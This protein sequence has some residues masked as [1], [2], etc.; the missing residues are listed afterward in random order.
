MDKITPP[1]GP[2]A[3]QPPGHTTGRPAGRPPHQPADSDAFPAQY[4]RTRRFSLGAPRAFTLAPDGS[5]ALFLRTRGPEDATGCLWRAD[6]AGEH[7]LLDPA[8]LD[9]AA[10]EIPE[11]ERIRRERAREHTS[12]IVGYATDAAARVIVLALDGELWTLRCDGGALRRVRT[13]GPVVD[14]RPDPLGRRV[15]YVTGGAL[16]VVE[17]DGGD[18]D[19]GDTDGG[20]SDGGEDRLLAGPEGPEVVYGLAEHVA[21]ESMHRHRGYWWAPDGERLLAARVDTSPV[22]R[23]WI[24]DPADPARPPRA[25]PYPAA[26]TANADVSLHVLGV[27]GSRT[28]VAWDRAAFEYLT[29]AAWD[30]HGPLIGVQ[31]RDQRTLRVLGCD[32]DTG[33]THLLHEQRDPAWVELVPGTP[34]RTASGA[35]VHTVDDGAT[36]RLTVGGEP[37]TPEGLQ[38]RDVLSVDGGSVLFVASDEP[39]EEHLWSYAPPHGDGSGV[40]A[41][42]V[43]LSD[44]PGLHE[45]RRAGDTLLLISHT[46]D[47][48]VF[49]LSAGGRS[50]PIASLAARPAVVPRPLWLRAGEHEVRTALLLPSWYRLPGKEAGDSGGREPEAEGRGARVRETSDGRDPDGG[51]LPLPVLMAPYGGPALQLAVRARTARLCEAQWFAEQGFAVVVADGR[52]TPGRGPEWDKSIHLDSL[53]GP[54]EDQVTALHAAAE[55]LAARGGRLDLGRVAVR[56]W[57]FGGSLAT[58]AVLRRPD[59]FHA[60]ICGAGPSDQRLYDT[61]WRERF[62]GHPDEEPEAYRRSSPIEEAAALTRPLLLVHGMAD[63]NVVPA[64]TL[65]MSAAL[66]A[67]GRPHQVLPLSHV[68]HSPSD[69]VVVEGLLRHQLDFLRASLN[70]AASRPV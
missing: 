57:S 20:G 29:S 7:L 32:P 70:T 17:L 1:A 2:P 26:G 16:R 23:W 46:E 31:S 68:T 62:L 63:D 22:S 19:G 51:P 39:T 65:R 35:L 41:G 13:A 54:V 64:H 6:E 40:G 48:D 44:G 52:G 11:A 58:M 45:G 59:V 15:A 37:V 8:A 3:H 60:A 14:P 25:V 69:P 34:A 49:R 67:A 24:A 56:G 47:G 27:D 12:G 38:V 5:F 30:A 42:P 53:G 36:R 10:G 28:E 55:H 21:S 50:R 61:H 33:A 4:A 18:T 43:R 66:L 9:R